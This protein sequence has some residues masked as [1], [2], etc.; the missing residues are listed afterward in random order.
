MNWRFL[1]LGSGKSN[2]PEPVCIT[3]ADAAERLT[4]ETVDVGRGWA[5]ALGPQGPVEVDVTLVGPLAP[6]AVILAHGGVA[7]AVVEEGQDHA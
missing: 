3:C 2:A 6:G 1:E 5:R 7:L 4:V